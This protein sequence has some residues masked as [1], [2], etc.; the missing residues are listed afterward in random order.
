MTEPRR[1]LFKEGLA[2]GRVQTGYWNTM[3]DPLAAEMA[4]SLGYDWVVLDCEHSAMETATALSLMQAV[5]PY[6]TSAIVRPKVLDVAEIK[7]LLDLGAQSLLIPMINTVEEARLA[8]AAVSYPPDGIRGIAG[9][10]RAG[11]FGA[12]RDYHRTAREGIA[13]IVQIET[14]E[15]V[16]RIEEIAAV[17]GIDA[18]FI[19]PADLAGSLGHIGEASHPDVQAACEDAIRRI[20]AAGKPAGYLSADPEACDRMQAAGATFV[21]RDIDIVALH[22]ALAERAPKR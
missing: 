7:K 1:N 18:M 20:V 8:A 15:A 17:P 10:T 12:V 19:G 16:G 11:G 13:L 21:G 6:P 14:M 22:R 3:T 5:A 4:A 9:A 2:E